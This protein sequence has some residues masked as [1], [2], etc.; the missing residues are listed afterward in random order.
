M[1]VDA[2]M[3]V[4]SVEADPTVVAADLGT[5]EVAERGVKGVLALGESS[6]FA[7][8]SVDSTGVVPARRRLDDVF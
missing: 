5:V 2:D 3:G 4:G 8:R 6:N 1:S 7:D